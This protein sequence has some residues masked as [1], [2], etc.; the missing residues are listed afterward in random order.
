MVTKTDP[1]LQPF[2]LK[3][4]LLRNRI[5][6]T[7]HA[8]GY[9]VDGNPET[10]YQLY[11]AEKAKGGLALTMF[12]GSSNI[13]PDSPSV[14]GQ[15][16]AGRDQVIPH[17]Q[18]LA[19]AVRAEGAAIMCQLTHMGRR[20]TWNQADWLPVIAPSRL[21]EPA[22]RSFPK[23][24]DAYDIARTV[25]AYGAAARRC[26]EGDL[27]GLELLAHGHLLEQFWS[28][29]VNR[30]SDAY[31]G[32]RENRLR[33]SLEVLEEIRR[34]VGPDY[35]VGIRMGAES[36]LEGDLDLEE[37]LAIAEALER[38]GLIDFLN[39]NR[40]HIET[41]QA[42]AHM[43][44]GMADPLAPHL[45]VIGHFKSQ[46]TLPVF[47]ACRINDLAT[48]R[49]AVEAG[50]IDMVGM[51][52]AHI[53]DPHIVRKLIAGE[54]ERI[55]PCVGA[56]YCID[57]IYEGG[58]ALCLHNAATGR[59][60]EMPQVIPKAE[61]PQKTV[62]VVGGGP[63]GLEA[64]R[65][66]A[67]RGHKVVLF[68]AAKELGGQV[69]LAAKATWRRDLA[70]IVR[71]YESEL[72]HY[73]VTVKTN[74]YAEAEDILAE[75]PDVVIIASGGLPDPVLEENEELIRSTWDVLG[76][77]EPLAGDVLIYDD[78]GQ[79]QGPSCAEVLAEKGC[80][81]E[82][83]TADRMVAAEIGGLNYPIYLEHLY[84][85]GVTLTP[86]QR[87]QTVERAGNKL[88]VTLANEYTAARE[89]R[90]VDHLVV[91]HGTLP[92]V[93]VYDAL[94]GRAA[95]RGITDYEAL[96]SGRPQPWQPPKLA[97]ALE[98]GMAAP[99]APDSGAFQLFR[100]GDAVASRNIHAAIYDALRLC[101]D[102]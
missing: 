61:G 93:E 25:A 19:A 80:R 72:E 81:V 63:G 42:L 96:L 23:E 62:V 68:E 88:K 43:M 94:Q 6:S 41:N 69:T 55:R 15:I 87:L 20:T 11:H 37:N 12:G 74:H 60:A 91:E 45:R 30:R 86:D 76:G 99:D 3:G 77:T 83:A 40:G 97:A 98:T 75:A 4:L 24:M 26:K 36:T 14:F 100:I 52:R 39:V 22:H 78:N 28:P 2:H 90:V 71:W 13:A 54:E 10:R 29:R 50:L 44:P 17:F 79:H 67:A 16:N 53:A 102:L 32:S 95:N 70:G 7:S 92:L 47:H 21:R 31:G 84:K 38:S 1:L 46:V 73:G 56:G 85:L 58:E 48:A 59:E 49:H 82:L 34:Q 64:A 101:K 5:M 65:V 57:R 66:S 9:V 89:T 8:P 27:D 51:T 33:F 35:I 18:A